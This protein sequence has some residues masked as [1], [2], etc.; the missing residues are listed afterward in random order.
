MTFSSPR[1]TFDLRPLLARAR[2]S[3]TRKATM[4]GTMRTKTAIVSFVLGLLSVTSLTAVAGV[5]E[6]DG[7]PFSN[8]GNCET[9]HETSQT[10]TRLGTPPGHL[11]TGGVLEGTG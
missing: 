11:G 1:H 8:G 3:R 5:I 2:R 9:S 10:K 7:V 4:E 6:G